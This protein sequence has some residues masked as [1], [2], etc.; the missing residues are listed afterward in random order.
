MR[1]L[2]ST[3]FYRPELTGVAKYTT[4]L[5]EFLAARGHDVHVV[6]PP[7]YYPSWRAQKPYRQWRY[8]GE[9]LGGVR[10]HRCPIWVPR[11]PKGMA[12][13]LYGLSFTLSALPVMLRQALASPDL[14]LVIEPSFQNVVSA[15]VASRVAGAAA[16]LHIQDF[17]IDLAYDL[18][19]LRR[20]RGLVSSVESWLMKRFDVVSSITDGMVGK[21]RRKGVAEDSLYLL[22]NWVDPAAIHPLPSGSP[23]RG[24]LGIP[25]E[26]AVAMFAGSL[27]PKQ[28]VEMIIDAAELL[29]ADRSLEFVICGEGV[30]GA[31]LRERARGLHNVRFLPLQPPD[32]LNDLLNLADLHL[33]PGQPSASGSVMPSKVTGMLASGRPVIA[34]C[35]R[36][37]ELAELIAG[38]GV[39]VE[40]GN[41]RDFADAIRLLAGNSALSSRFGTWGRRRALDRFHQAQILSDF[42]AEV[43]RRIRPARKEADRL[44]SQ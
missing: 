21:V 15:W 12:R 35:P 17:E 36:D 37:S 19:Q 33:L 32:R 16:W 3:I 2:V 6:A 44:A 1:I 43:H 27:G 39:V 40:P 18:A 22:P 42:E 8:Q 11:Q 7:P 34:A 23:M 5:C 20:G 14:V 10:I 4:E 38:C 29:A 9:T 31:S 30:A 25:N 24:A 26:S 41:V 28:G 13:L